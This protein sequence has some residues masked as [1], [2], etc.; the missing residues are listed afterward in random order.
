MGPQ[1]TRTYLAILIASTIVCFI[2]IYL[3]FLVL[4]QQRRNLDL[5]R[6]MALAEINTLEQERTRVAADLHDDLAPVLAA[7]KFRISSMQPASAEDK[8]GIITSMRYLD[9]S[10]VK[11]REIS[12]DLMPTMLTKQGIIDSLKDLININSAKSNLDIRFE[13]PFHLEISSELERQLYRIVQESIMN[14]VKHASASQMLIK[15]SI[16]SGKLLLVIKDNGTGFDVTKVNS[17]KDSRGLDSLRNR[18]KMIG[19]KFSIFS[20]PDKGTILE[21]EVPLS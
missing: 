9:Q 5:Q 20:A 19:G 2:L 7:V 6:K 18:S 15:L 4:R 3:L 10:I 14:C 1:E 13:S 8:E 11:L 16:Q 21:I 17:K 12:N